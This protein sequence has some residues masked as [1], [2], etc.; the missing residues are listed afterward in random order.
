MNEEKKL[1]KS[2]E[3][4]KFLGVSRRTIQY[5][6]RNKILT[7]DEVHK[8]NYREYNYFSE[9]NLQ[10]CAKLFD[11]KSSQV[12]KVRKNE[13]SQNS[14]AQNN[15]EKNIQLQPAKELFIAIDKLKKRIFDATDDS[16]E[17]DVIEDKKLKLI[18]PLDIRFSS[19]FEG[20]NSLTAYDELIFDICAS[21]QFK[22]NMYTT[23]AIIHRAM[24][25]SKTKLTTK[26][27][28]KILRSVRKLA[29][30]WI[31]FD[32]SAICKK[33]GYNNGESYKYSGYLLPAEYVTKT[34]NGRVDTA[35]IHFLQKSPLLDV[36]TIKQ[37]LISCDVALLDVPNVR[38]T[39]Q[40]LTLKSY[41]LRR[42]L[43]IVGSYGKHNKHFRGK[44][45]GGGILTKQAK[46]LNKSILLDTLFEQCGLSDAPNN[47]KAEYRKTIE[48][49]LNHFQSQNLIL[50]WKWEKPD[51]KIRAVKIDF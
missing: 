15:E 37:Q 17:R 7:P 20:A 10:K 43:Q 40:V 26:D 3:A 22:G 2:S 18:T 29:T 48:K 12:L 50:K 24:G 39:E 13:S 49:I 9:E 1:L 41:V 21:E 27:K 31:E 32:I 36:A 19:A 16:T 4:A 5:W 8:N 45:K 28:E 47:R 33:F 42:V 44:K 51:G 46:K 11:K 23:P 6:V 35:V 38:N 25:G 30:T 34:I 14:S